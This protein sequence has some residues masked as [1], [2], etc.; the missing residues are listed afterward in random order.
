MRSDFP[1]EQEVDA[2]F[3][4]KVFLVYLKLEGMTNPPRVTFSQYN[5]SLCPPNQAQGFNLCSLG[6]FV[7]VFVFFSNLTETRDTWE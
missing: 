4:L 6:V 2:K 7:F 5:E 1:L 3:I